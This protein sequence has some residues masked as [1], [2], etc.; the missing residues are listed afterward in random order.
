[1]NLVL[2]TLQEH[3]M[4]DDTVTVSL[5]NGLEVR[6]LSLEW[7]IIQAL[8][9]AFRD[10]FADLLHIFDL[11]L[12]LDDDPDWGR[13]AEIARSEGWTDI[14]RYATAFVCDALGRPSPLPRRIARWR[15]KLIESVWSRDLLLQ[16]ADSIVTSMRRQSALDVLTRGRTQEL[17]GAY[18][19][20]LTP[21]REVIDLRAGPTDDPYPV[22]LFRWRLSQARSNADMRE[23]AEITKDLETDEAV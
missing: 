5:P 16:G 15:L 19:K 4:W 18:A 20:R 1:M 10:N 7:A 2:P 21:P 9:H 6:T 22:A 23:D 13:I 3:E 8:L 17:V 14:I 11:D 12:M